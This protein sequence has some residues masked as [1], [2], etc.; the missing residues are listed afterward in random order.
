MA[1]IFIEGLLKVVSMV[2]G[3]KLT[4]INGLVVVDGKD[5]TPEGG[6]I[7]IRVDGDLES[8]VVNVAAEN[9]NAMAT[10][11]V[12]GNVNN[13]KTGS[14]DVV[15]GQNVCGGIQTTSGD[16]E[17]GGRVAGGVVTGSGDVNCGPV[18]GTIATTS[19]DVT[20]GPIMGNIRT[21]SGDIYHSM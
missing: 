16:V 1:N 21:G 2:T 19:G 5:V 7:S 11:G 14:G 15:V 12:S 6:V 17:V 4:I 13:I 8:L 20:S 10:I 3:S 18:D 9:G